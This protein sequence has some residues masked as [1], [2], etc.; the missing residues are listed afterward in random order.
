MKR[1]CQKRKATSPAGGKIHYPEPRAERPMAAGRGSSAFETRQDADLHGRLAKNQG[2]PMLPAALY[3]WS[4]NPKNKNGFTGSQKPYFYEKTPE[5]FKIF[6]KDALK[7]TF[8][9]KWKIAFSLILVSQKNN[10]RHSGGENCGENAQRT[11][12]MHEQQK[13]KKAHGPNTTWKRQTAFN[14]AVSRA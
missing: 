9:K 8:P 1:L 6:A 2:N 3:F 5:C 11:Q 7:T 12:R 10:C 4:Q 14:A 13:R